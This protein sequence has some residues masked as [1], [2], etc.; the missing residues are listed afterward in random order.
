[1]FSDVTVV[2]ESIVLLAENENDDAKPIDVRLQVRNY[3]AIEHLRSHEPIHASAAHSHHMVVEFIVL[4]GKTA[5]ADFDC[6]SREKN[7]RGL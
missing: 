4:L 5:V 6:V 3:T 7:I 1:M 2:W